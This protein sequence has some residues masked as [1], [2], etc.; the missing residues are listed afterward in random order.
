MP[1]KTLL[2]IPSDEIVNFV[3]RNPIDW[4]RLELARRGGVGDQAGM[5]PT[6]AVEEFLDLLI[7]GQKLFTQREYLC[8]CW[9]KWRDWVLSKTQS[10]KLGVKAKLYRNFYPAM[11]DSLHVWAMLCESGMFDTCVMNSVE[12]AIG[13]TDL[14]VRSKNRIYRIALLGPTSSA[15]NDRQ[16]KL[17]HRN[18]NGADVRCV[19]IQMPESYS[20]AIGNKRWFRRSDIMGALLAAEADTYEQ[21]EPVF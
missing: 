9:N 2:Y 4:D 6:P 14:L 20:K 21:L 11:I 7:E 13:K 5:P 19:E 16:Y 17:T 8:H 10:Q 1:G 3:S 18:G 15:A 12:D